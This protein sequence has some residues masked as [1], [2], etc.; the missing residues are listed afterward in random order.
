MVSDGA[1]DSLGI[2]SSLAD[3]HVDDNLLETGDKV[4][5]AVLVLLLKLRTNLLEVD[6][7]QTRRVIH[8]RTL[9]LRGFKRRER[10]TPPRTTLGAKQ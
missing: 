5:V 2:G 7:L 3:A 1:V 4:H 8:E 6:S 10:P 9:L